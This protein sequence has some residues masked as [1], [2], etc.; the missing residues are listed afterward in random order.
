MNKDVIADMAFLAEYMDV[1]LLDR[2]SLHLGMP[3]NS[4][5]WVAYESADD[6]IKAYGVA[7]AV[8]QSF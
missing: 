8:Q 5:I 3:A 1:D 4:V 2:S 7:N 6:F